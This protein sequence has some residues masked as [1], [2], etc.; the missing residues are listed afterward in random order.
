VAKYKAQETPIASVTLNL[1]GTDYPLTPIAG[2]RKEELL[3]AVQEWFVVTDELLAKLENTSKLSMKTT[4]A[5]GKTRKDEPGKSFIND[6]RRL[7]SITKEN[8][9]QQENIAFV[10]NDYTIF[11]PDVN[12][13]DLVPALIYN[14]NY[15]TFSKK[16]QLKSYYYQ[17]SSSS[18]LK[19]LAFYNVIS[20]SDGISFCGWLSFQPQDNGTW[21]SLD[22]LDTNRITR[23]SKM[24]TTGNSGIMNLYSAS[25]LV[26]SII[27]AYKLF[28]G[29]YDYGFIWEPIIGEK[30]SKNITRAKW[31]PGPFVVSRVNTKLFP[32][33]E[34][35]NKG[36]II[37]E[38]NGISTE[39]MNYIDTLLSLVCSGKKVTFTLK[40]SL[41]N[42]K[43]LSVQPK[44]TPAESN[45]KN[46][47]AIIE[48][49]SRQFIKFDNNR[50]YPFDFPM[51]YNPLASGIQ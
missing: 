42:Q 7:A 18:D 8:Y 47:K 35:M 40:D 24:E 27:D 26:N 5:N 45:T 13:A 33:L 46:F 31:R 23:W 44:F 38:I 1:D 12:P 16:E 17:F 36:D 25:D 30:D 32:E 22:L 39:K 49:D 34:Q 4:Y 6:I 48:K 50:D 15:E 41:G 51:S 28:H 29:T 9:K 20:R 43:I 3:G 10:K 19:Y 11:I 2:A 37:T 14:V 21:V